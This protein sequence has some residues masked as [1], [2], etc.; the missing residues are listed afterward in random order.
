[1]K[2]K[3]K[4][5]QFNSMRNHL[6]FAYFFTFLLFIAVVF[7]S[8]INVTK[9]S[10]FKEIS[11]SRKD[12]LKQVSERANVVKNSSITALNLMSYDGYIVEQ[13]KQESVDNDEALRDYINNQQKT[14]NH[15][16]NDVNIKYNVIIMS[17]NGFNYNFEERD[18]DYV[19]LKNQLWFKNIYDKNGDITF[20]SSFNDK[21]GSGE[22]K[23]VFSASR[24]LK[25]ENG[26]DLATIMITVS[27][28][29]LRRLY[30]PLL[31]ENSII[32][33]VDRN[34]NIISHQDQSF[35]GLNYFSH[36]NFANLYPESDYLI[37]NK[38]HGD[39]LFSMVHDEATGWTIIEETST[40]YVFNEAY[41][42]INYI[43][44]A[45]V[46][47]VLVALF[48]SYYVSRHISQPLYDLAKSMKKLEAGNFDIRSDI[49]SYNEVNDLSTTFNEMVMQI[50]ELLKTIVTHESYRKDLEMN[51]LRAQINPHFLYNTLF[52]IRC[53]AEMDRKDKLL[54]MIDAF[55]GLLN[56]TFS[57]DTSLVTVEKELE[58]TEKY[59]RLQQIRYEDRFIFEIEVEE[60]LLKEEVP[61][62]ILQPIVENSIFH[63]IEP[64]HDYGGITIHV[65]SLNESFFS[66]DI[67]DNGI[68]ISDT[69]IEKIKGSLADFSLQPS[70]SIGLVNVAN[71]I[72]LTYNGE[73]KFD[74]ISEKHV[75]TIIRL[76]IPKTNKKESI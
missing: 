23:Y 51:F 42:T 57:S 9:Q 11:A 69:T 21:F 26:E 64:K 18:Y 34:G 4:K 5:K 52:S 58:S 35:L 25:D 74:I 41:Q 45:M 47:C 38:S 20:I 56:S 33:I 39:Y 71:R 50:D 1:M 30:E 28:T 66:I 14:Y 40:R 68:G 48:I 72:H 7:L 60:D 19:N 24:Q 65:Y 63:G 6:F 13:F 55:T 70:E 29:Y 67:I 32:Y 54:D 31:D 15:V 36:D 59:L 37:I 76:I 44:F 3:R 8:L 17:N 61:V 53:M 10:L 2:D 16:F 73:G 27:E 12:V 49:K 22:D 75:G 43:I 46:I 62:L